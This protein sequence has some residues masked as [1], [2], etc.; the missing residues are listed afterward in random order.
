MTPNLFVD[1]LISIAFH[2]DTAQDS[3][4]FNG[5]VCRELSLGPSS[6][7]QDPKSI[8]SQKKQK[9]LNRFRVP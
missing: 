5:V 3:S 6:V 2:C 4:E 1:R 9:G 8:S 7:I